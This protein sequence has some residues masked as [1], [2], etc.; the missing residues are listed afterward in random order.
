MAK[1]KIYEAKDG[2]RWRL[3]SNGRIIAD[4]GEAYASRNNA[5]RAAKR[6]MDIVVMEVE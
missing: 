4:S 3:L 5:K 1:F 6:L 2:W